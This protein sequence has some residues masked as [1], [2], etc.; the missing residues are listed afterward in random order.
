MG[1]IIA[2]I[3]QIIRVWVT[4][5][6][7]R[8]ANSTIFMTRAIV[9]TCFFNNKTAQYLD[10]V[11]YTPSL[12]VSRQTSL[13]I[14]FSYLSQ[15]FPRNQSSHAFKNSMVGLLRVVIPNLSRRIQKWPGFSVRFFH[16]QFANAICISHKIWHTTKLKGAESRRCRRELYCFCLLVFLVPLTN[17]V[18]VFFP[19]HSKKYTPQFG[20]VFQNSLKPT[21]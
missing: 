21:T 17:N 8:Y 15:K 13:K 11:F 20:W 10:E 7:L 5:A 19:H 1:S 2:Y 3:Q 16:A 9:V 6:H 18:L 12:G 4:T 14:Y